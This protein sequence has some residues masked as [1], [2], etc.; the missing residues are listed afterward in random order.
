MQDRAAET[1]VVAV[2]FALD[3][4][5]SGNVIEEFGQH[6]CQDTDNLLGVGNR[7]RKEK[8]DT[9]YEFGFPELARC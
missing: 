2:V 3:L 1:P 8:I 4:A 7:L 5:L 9:S 6:A